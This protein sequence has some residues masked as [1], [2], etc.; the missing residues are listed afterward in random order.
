MF[1][2]IGNIYDVAPRA[3]HQLLQP[4][5]GELSCRSRLLGYQMFCDT[6]RLRLSVETMDEIDPV[7]T[8]NAQHTSDGERWLD[9]LCRRLDEAGILYLINCFEA[10]AAGNPVGEESEYSS[11]DFE[12]RYRARKTL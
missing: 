11:P 3:L 10:D 2:V 1:R 7:Y 12:S 4:C 9:G 8:L 6:P 5:V